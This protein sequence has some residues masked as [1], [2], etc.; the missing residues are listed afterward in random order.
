MKVESNGKYKTETPNEWTDFWRSIV[1]V[2]VFPTDTQ[3]RNDY[4]KRWSEWQD[5][6]R[7]DQFGV[8]RS[9]NKSMNDKRTFV[10]GK[11]AFHV[12]TNIM[13]LVVTTIFYDVFLGNKSIIGSQ[14]DCF[15]VGEPM[16]SD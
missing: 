2:N 11:S 15:M 13:N 5:R 16:R 14:S 6:N 3:N 4:T 1:G 10:M 7:A 12:V 9:M 8:Y